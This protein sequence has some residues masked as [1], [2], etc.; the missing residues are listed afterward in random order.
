MDLDLE[1]GLSAKS[2]KKQRARQKRRQVLLPQRVVGSSVSTFMSPV[3][4]AEQESWAQNIWELCRRKALAEGRRTK[5]L[6]EDVKVKLG[7]ANLKY[8][9]GR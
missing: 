6:P 3:Y 4:M 9:M 1:L 5:E 2:R 8:A 7:E